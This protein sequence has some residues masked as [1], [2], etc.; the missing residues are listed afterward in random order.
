MKNLPLAE[1]CLFAT[2]KG[3][4]SSVKAFVLTQVLIAIL[5]LTTLGSVY[6]FLTKS[7]ANPSYSQT[8]PVTTQPASLNLNL[9]S[10]DDDLMVF[11]SSVVVSGKTLP[12]IYVLVS[13]DSDDFIIKSKEDGTFSGDLELELGQ[14]ELTVSAFDSSGDSREAKRTIFYSKEKI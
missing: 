4:I 3:K 2:Q 7:S 6:Y 1:S 11:N 10:P 13:S 14:N 8:G 9:D 5:L 12:N